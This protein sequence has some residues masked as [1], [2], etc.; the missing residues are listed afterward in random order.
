MQRQPERVLVTGGGGFL[1]FAVCERLRNRGDSVVSL[2]R[3]RYPALEQ[4][5]VHQITGDIRDPDAVADACR[6][7]DVVFH[8]AA[9]PGVS[10]PYAQYAAVNVTGTENVLNGCRKH[11][12]ARLVYT[13]SPSVVFDGSDM[14]GVDESVPYPARYEAAY[15]ETKAMAEKLVVAAGRK[16]APMTISLRPHLIWGPRD[17]HLVPRILARAEK[18]KR[19]GSGDNLVDTVY[20]DNAADA[21]IR[22]ADRL[23][24][25]PQLSGNVYFISQDD[26]IPVWEM[27]DR[28]LAAG[29][30]GPVKGSVPV[31]VARAAGW[32]LETIYRIFRLNGEPPMT[33]F[34]AREL[35]TAHWFDITA[36]RQ[37]LGYV[38]EVS[39]D[40]GLRRLAEWLKAGGGG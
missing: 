16:K 11:R 23:A 14:A 26:P 18:L 10:G 29:G 30:K 39:T 38:P 5:G 34:L 1:G 3:H 27:V 33:R 25:S 21:H 20:V 17:N 4:I 32:A 15:P 9:R 7:R 24:E 12:V 8:V 6:D 37:D 40:E 22:A 19:I 2:S 13:S 31:P 36:A 35:S 28:I